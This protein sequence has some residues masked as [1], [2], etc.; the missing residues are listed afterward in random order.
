M[1][2]FSSLTSTQMD[3]GYWSLGDRGYS[4][5]QGGT[6]VFS[7][8]DSF[9]MI[10]GNHD[11]KAGGGIRANQMNVLAEGFQDGYWIYT[12]LW[13]GEPMIGSGSRVTISPSSSTSPDTAAPSRPAG[14]RRAH[15][16]GS[17]VT[18][19]AAMASTR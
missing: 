2:S 15:R 14:R 4:P 1:N 5:F 10:R 3:G 12:G 8:S 17:A 11:I 9:D 16:T 19:P 7:I 13:G 18:A 6:N